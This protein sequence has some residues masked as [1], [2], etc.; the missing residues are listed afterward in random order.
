M[1][2]VRKFRGSEP[3]AAAVVFLLFLSGVSR[4]TDLGPQAGD[5]VVLKW[6][7]ALLQA[8]RETK[9][10][11]TVVARAIAVVHA[12]IFDAWAAYDAVAV[13]TRPHREWRRPSGEQDD[14]HRAEALSFAAVRALSDL[15][16]AQIPEFNTLMSSLGY[17]VS[18]LSRDPRTPAGIG[19]SAAEA[20]LRFRHADGSNQ[21]GNLHPGAYSDYTGYT[22]VNPPEPAPVVDP[23]HWQ[24][25]QVSDGNGGFV[26][27]QYT[28]PQW[29]LVTPFALTSGAQF[30]PGPPVLYPSADYLTQANQL[31]AL[32]AG[33]TDA[34]KA[35]AEYFADGPSSEFPP[36]IGA[37]SRNS[38][39]GGTDI[40]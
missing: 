34:E 7:E 19:N 36:G 28:T 32:S 11:P 40:R 24:Q 5:N 13:P 39:R 27:Q 29:G 23:N 37:C 26:I 22:P 14:A 20:V 33:L 25:L 16:P 8:V 1:S 31:I 3:A 18:D 35:T 4:A 2:T 9:P 12:A 21:L 30:R 15:F 38:C 10:G 6:N 17:D